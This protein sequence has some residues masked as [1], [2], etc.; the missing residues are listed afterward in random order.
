MN[1]NNIRESKE[2]LPTSSTMGPIQENG[3]FIKLS[4][5]DKQKIL[6][7]LNQ[8]NQNKPI[9]P[10]K[11]PG[12]PNYSTLADKCT[13]REEYHNSLDK[14]IAK[15]SKITDDLCSHNDKV[16]KEITEHFPAALRSTVEKFVKEAQEN[17]EGF[18]DHAQKHKD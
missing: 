18:K 5:E 11:N 3:E 2:Q 15:H 1:N 16:V 8:L 13:T 17:R 9:P 14:F 7:Q 6:Q 12:Y 4:L 10:F